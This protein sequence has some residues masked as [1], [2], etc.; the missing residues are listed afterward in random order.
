MG[1]SWLGRR[2]RVGR[3]TWRALRGAQGANSCPLGPSATSFAVCWR[4]QHGPAGPRPR[5]CIAALVAYLAAH[6]YDHA[7]SAKLLT[8]PTSKEFLHVVQFLFKRVD[9][10][11]RFIGKP[12][13][14]IPVV[15]KRLGYPFTISK[16]AL[17]SVGSPHTWP[18]LLAALSWVV[19][20]LTYEERAEEGKAAAAAG[21]G[22]GGGSGFDDSGQRLFFEYVGGAYQQYLSDD[23][24]DSEALDEALGAR[25]AERDAEAA[26]E[27]ER[28][29]IVH[30]ELAAEATVA[31]ARP[32][33]L[34]ALEAR[35]T[36]FLSDIGKFNKLV[37]NLQVCYAP[38]HA[39]AIVVQRL[40]YHD[41]RYVVDL[42]M[43]SGA[44]VGGRAA[45]QHKVALEAKVAERHE[46]LGVRSAELAAAGTENEALRARVAAQS[47]N[48]ADAERM[49]RERSAAETALR[50]VAGQLEELERAVWAAEVQLSRRLEELEAAV[51]LY[52]TT[53]DRL[54]VIPASAKRAGGVAY[55]VALNSRA[56]RPEDMLGV[57]VKGLIKPALAA[58]KDSYATRARDGQQNLLVL[59]EKVDATSEGLAEKQ[60]QTAALEASNRKLEAQFKEEKAEAEAEFGALAAEARRCSDAAAAARTAAGEDLASSQAQYEAAVAEREHGAAECRQEAAA[61]GVSLLGAL[62][63]LMSH[64]Q[65]VQDT[66]TRLQAVTER[67]LGAPL[68]GTTLAMLAEDNSSGSG[69]GIDLP[70]LHIR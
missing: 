33:P 63:A 60:E 8:A 66:L 10:N 6:G 23:R 61:L 38:L 45:Q 27:L 16:S 32:P 1:K 22:S 34:A 18:G 25:F 55:E 3:A 53:G 42:L 65:H 21:G 57:D 64:K 2:E 24:F 69:V 39:A 59:Q 43:S 67:A 62:D 20:L 4:R 56:S 13:D 11:I 37:T 41:F 14:E 30:A 31:K 58:L 7:I 40:A 5:G 46:E 68:N 15:F 49:G 47:V 35:R 70:S 51:R 29:D 19:E 12:E 9:P 17:Y 44:T 50:G 54:K 36:D 28:L 48:L 52:H 26:A